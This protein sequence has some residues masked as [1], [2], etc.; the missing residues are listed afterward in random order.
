MLFAQAV[1]PPMQLPPLGPMLGVV[2]GLVLLGPL[3]WGIK[4]P[5]AWIVVSFLAIA[6]GVGCAGYGCAQVFIFDGAHT[7]SDQ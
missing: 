1:D 2:F 6:A 3:L 4:E 5:L 7:H